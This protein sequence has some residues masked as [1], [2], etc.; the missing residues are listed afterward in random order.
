VMP[1]GDL[2]RVAPVWCPCSAGAGN[3]PDPLAAPAPCLRIA[4]LVP[5]HPPPGPNPSL[6]WQLAV[7]RIWLLVAWA[8]APA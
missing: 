1:A 5:C 6:H 8:P 4:R 2:R 3:K 7:G